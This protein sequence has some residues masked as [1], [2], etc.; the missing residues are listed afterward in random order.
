[1]TIVALKK[2]T[3]CGL[4]NEKRGLLSELQGL[5]CLHLKPLR[6]APAEPEKAA[7]PRAE[8]AY[9]ALKFLSDMPNKRKQVRRDPS[10]DVG[11]VVEQ[12]REVQESLRDAEDRRDFLVHRIKQIEPWGDLT[13][14]PQAELAGY[15]LW[16]YV[17]PAGKRK[18]LESLEIPWQ[19]VHLDQRRAY[20]VLLAEEE[21]P[22]DILPV[23]RIHTGALPL[24]MLKQQLEEVEVEIES[25]V[26]ERQ[27]LT[28]FVY[29]LSVNLA[30]SEDAAALN[31]ATEQTHDEPDIFAVQGWVPVPALTEVRAFAEERGLACLIEEPEPD[32]SPPTLLDNP[33]ELGAATDLALFYQTPGY[34]SWDPALVVFFSFALFFAMIISDAGYAL[35]MLALLGFYWG[36]LSVSAGGRRVRNLCGC[37]FGASLVWGVLAGGYFGVTPPDDSLLGWFHV[38]DLNNFDLMM[39]LSIIVGTL[40]IMLANGIV[41]YLNWQH[42]S[43]AFPKLGWNSV[44][45]GGLV[46]WLSGGEGFFGILAWLLFLGGLAAIFWFS[47]ERPFDNAKDAIL[48]IVEGLKALTGLSGLFGDV[49]SYMRLFALGLASASLAL[50]FNQLAVQVEEA[51]PGLGMLLAILILLIGHVLNLGLAIMSGVVHGLRLNFIE[52]YKWGMSEE[53]YPF[54][55]FARKEVQP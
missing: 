43:V 51:V 28:R 39:K 19:I 30:K 26:A 13:F 48:R 10:F 34:R 21:P 36:K 27:A 44:T 7:S 54:K 6:S 42:Y 5:G 4:L 53:G 16:F 25:L 40:H 46:L 49:L 9:K 11:K 12:A 37:L 14:P 45:L 15:R 32:D 24:E 52:F 33:P 17:L 55:A 22:S 47:S 50:T 2:V 31:H 23:D 38:I 35:V 1:M 29:L 20:V 41:A 18:F 8:E 3:L